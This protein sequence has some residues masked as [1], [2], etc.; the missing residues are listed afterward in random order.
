MKCD[1]R[2][3]LLGRGLSRDRE[4]VTNHLTILISIHDNCSV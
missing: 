3:N 1:E 4:K 2:E